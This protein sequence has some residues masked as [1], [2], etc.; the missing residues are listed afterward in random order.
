MVLT[1][2]WVQV[3]QIE[4]IPTYPMHALGFPDNRSTV[5]IGAYEP[6]HIYTLFIHGESF[7]DG[8]LNFLFLYETIY[9]KPFSD[10]NLS[11]LFL[12]E[13]ICIKKCMSYKVNFIHIR[14]LIP[15]C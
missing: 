10:W 7:S 14:I 11:L 1:F 12:Y 6:A 2:E 3:F 5:H 9:I 4:S 13:S 8:N 15:I